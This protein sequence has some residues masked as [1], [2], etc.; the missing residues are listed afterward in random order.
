[1][2][3]GGF[4]QSR[5]AEPEALSAFLQVRY[6]SGSSLTGHFPVFQF[7]MLKALFASSFQSLFFLVPSTVLRGV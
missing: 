4:I 2:T 7:V 6:S 3:G 5:F 1:M